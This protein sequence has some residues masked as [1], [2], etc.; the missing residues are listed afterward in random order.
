MAPEQTPGTRTT[1][2][3]EEID[4]KVEVKISD[5]AEV[6]VFHA[7]PFEEELSWVEFDLDRKS[8]DFILNNG[9]TRNLA[10]RVPEG[11][12]KHLQNTYQVMLVQMNEETGEPVSGKYFPLIIHRA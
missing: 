3:V 8:L 6:F 5:A 9:K 4:F 1:R 2:N 7:I 10:T 12:E 11:L